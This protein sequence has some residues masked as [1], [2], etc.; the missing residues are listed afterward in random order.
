MME[1]WVMTPSYRGPHMNALMRIKPAYGLHNIHYAKLKT[2]KDLARSLRRSRAVSG[3]RFKDTR[4][5]CCL[6]VPDA[7]KLFRV[8]E[9]TVR[10]WE[11][12]RAM[13]PYAAFKLM[14]ILRGYELPGHHWKGYRLKGDTLWSPEGL[15]FKASDATWW[16]LTCLMARQFR[17][18][19]ASARTSS[20]TGEAGTA[21]LVS[22]TTSIRG[23]EKPTNGAPLSLLPWPY[24]GAIMGPHLGAGNDSRNRQAQPTPA[25]RTARPN[26]R[27]RQVAGSLDQQPDRATAP[28]GTHLEG[29]PESAGEPRQ[30]PRAGGASHQQLA[31][32]RKERV[33]PLREPQ[34]GQGLPSRELQ[35]AGGAL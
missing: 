18:I 19:M 26:R 24:D 13:V 29:Q 23:I 5:L 3:S 31:Q 21:G 20:G 35:I 1:A 30:Q 7:G 22:S 11:A 32:G 16:S 8:T 17:I 25:S 34:E 2:P 4:L 28:E 15:P 27:S 6:S 14:R 9:R 33:L 10:N 12:G